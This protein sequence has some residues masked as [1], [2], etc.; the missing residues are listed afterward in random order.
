[1]CMPEHELLHLEA[2]RTST[3]QATV[4]LFFGIFWGSSPAK[5]SILGNFDLT[6]V[7]EGSPDP[8]SIFREPGPRGKLLSTHLGTRSGTVWSNHFL[9]PR[10]HG[11][12]VPS[13]LSQNQVTRFTGGKSLCFLKTRLMISLKFRQCAAMMSVGTRSKSQKN[14]EERVR[15]RPDP[16]IVGYYS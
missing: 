14:R 6:T 8:G 1:M 13:K 12:K 4:V 3:V 9:V 11:S 2:N 10:E 5:M 16:R 15:A 7:L